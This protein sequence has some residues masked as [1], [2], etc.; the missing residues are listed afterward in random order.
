MRT[1]LAILLALSAMPCLAQRQ[2]SPYMPDYSDVETWQPLV[3]NPKL[4]TANYVMSPADL[5]LVVNAPAGAA[6]TLPGPCMAGWVRMVV[7]A[8]PFFESDG[9]TL[10]P[11]VTIAPATGDNWIAP[12]TTAS[13]PGAYPTTL[14]PGNVLKLRAIGSAGSCIGWAKAN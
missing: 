12:V 10:L 3:W 11:P 5:V 8:S 4:V 2:A 1:I 13:G 9:V 14:N 7:N 6:I